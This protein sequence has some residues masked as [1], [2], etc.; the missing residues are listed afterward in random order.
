MNKKQLNH[1]ETNSSLKIDYF[2]KKINLS[3]AKAHLGRYLKAASSGER[4]V[5]SERN[6][7]IV[8]LV[9]IS[10]PKTKKL[11]PGLLAGKFTVPDNFNSPLIEFESDF[12]GE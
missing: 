8:E 3:E 6:R 10:M 5:I 1:S 9:A 7:P 2:M 11:K 4:I 12:Y